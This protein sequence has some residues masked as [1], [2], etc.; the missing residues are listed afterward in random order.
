MALQYSGFRPQ[1][2]DDGEPS[3]SLDRLLIRN[4]HASFF[5]LMRG[6][7]MARAGIRHNDVLVIEAAEEYRDGCIVLAFIDH[8]AL[9][10]RLERTPT[11]FNLAPA[12]PRY[13]TL[14]VGEDITIR[15]QVVAAVTLL[16]RPRAKLAVV[17]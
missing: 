11:G 12:N 1:A 5:A 7:A 3:L 13:P 2:A 8:Q 9:V 4:P 15:G 6:N 10:R 16:A 17:S 14:S